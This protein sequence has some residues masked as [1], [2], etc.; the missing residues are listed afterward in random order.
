MKTEKK[1][2]R[3]LLLQSLGAVI[4]FACLFQAGFAARKSWL[5]SK[6]KASI[7]DGNIN[8]AMQTGRKLA[9]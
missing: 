7:F 2:R 9:W 3:L 8:L 1:K 6:M 4:L 5:R